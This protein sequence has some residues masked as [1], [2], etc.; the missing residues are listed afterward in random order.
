M[1]PTYIQHQT[2][3]IYVVMHIILHAWL[4]FTKQIPLIGL[5]INWN[6]NAFLHKGYLLKVTIKVTLGVFTL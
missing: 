1:Q 3:I 6:V 5:L 2:Y 4:Y